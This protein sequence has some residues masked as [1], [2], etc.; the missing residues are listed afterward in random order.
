MISPKSRLGA[1]Y[2][3]HSETSLFGDQK[4]ISKCKVGWNV[5]L[6][7]KVIRDPYIE[8]GILIQTG[9]AKSSIQQTHSS[10]SSTRLQ[11]N[12]HLFSKAF[13]TVQNGVIPRGRALVR[14]FLVP[15]VGALLGKG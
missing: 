6:I 7:F 3:E 11:M 2:L 5:L 13:Q 12:C 9:S 15:V 4:T 14:R 10:K 1:P 8:E